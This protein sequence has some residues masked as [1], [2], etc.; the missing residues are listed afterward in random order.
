[1]SDDDAPPPEDP[2]VAAI[3][4]AVRALAQAPVREAPIP[5]PLSPEADR[6]RA[7]LRALEALLFAAEEPLDVDTLRRR[8][9]DA[10]DVGALLAAL[11]AEYAHR[12]VNLVRVAGKWR[13]QTASD[14]APLLQESRIV[15][16]KLSQAAME[17]LAVVAYHQPA[18]RADVES[19]RGV[20]VSKGSL[21]QLVE[22]G[23]VR[24]AGRR[25]APGR[26]MTYVTTDSFLIHFGLDSLSDLPRKDDFAAEGLLQPDA[27]ADFDVPDPAAHL[28]AALEA[29]DPEDAPHE[30]DEEPEFATDFL[31]EDDPQDAAEADPSRAAG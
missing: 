26:P 21:D 5:E 17:T 7:H 25:R 28:A 11:R 31:D 8:M 12:G 1:M 18:T 6:A 24:A 4:Q 30:A 23:W 2:T 20:A 10:P 3:R 14:L 19:V 13:F 22:I 29:L 9:P 16:K 27:P 15:P